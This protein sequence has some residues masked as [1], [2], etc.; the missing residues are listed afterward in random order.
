M[1][2]RFVDD[3]AVSDTSGRIAS[4]L[5]EKNMLRYL[6]QDISVSNILFPGRSTRNLG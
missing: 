6:A 3:I 2:L 5:E 1:R 4:I